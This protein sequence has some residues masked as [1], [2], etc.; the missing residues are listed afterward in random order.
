MQDNE[1]INKLVNRK[2]HLVQGGY[3]METH[4]MINISRW[5][6]TSSREKVSLEDKNGSLSDVTS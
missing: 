6:T 3:A 4:R 1:Q 5:E 2:R